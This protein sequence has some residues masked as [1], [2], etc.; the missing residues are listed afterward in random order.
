MHYFI[1]KYQIVTISFYLSKKSVNQFPYTT[2]LSNFRYFNS[3][4]NIQRQQEIHQ[5][6][7]NYLI[8]LDHWPEFREIQIPTTPYLCLK[9]QN[10]N[11]TALDMHLRWSNIWRTT[12]DHRDRSWGDCTMTISSLSQVSNILPTSIFVFRNYWYGARWTTGIAADDQNTFRCWSCRII[13]YSEMD[14]IKN[15][16]EVRLDHSMCTYDVYL[17]PVENG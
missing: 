14:L 13:C 11:T 5:S 3:C 17:F 16:V 4:C 2:L 8:R 15:N 10:K 6:K 7:Y 9:Y 12:N 1:I